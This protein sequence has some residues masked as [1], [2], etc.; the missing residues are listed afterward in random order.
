MNQS[1]AKYT[2]EEL[3]ELS[4]KR[5]GELMR[6][7]STPKIE[8]VVGY[9]F[10]GYN[11]PWATKLMGTKKY[12]KG[13]YAQPGVSAY[14]WGYN[15]PVV[16]NRKTEPW[17]AV[18]NEANP[19]RYF[20]FKVFP[21]GTPGYDKKMAHALIIDY[22][23]WRYFFLNPIQRTLDYLV[24]PYPENRNLMVGRS[25]FFAGRIHF[26]MGYLILERHN[27]SNYEPLRKS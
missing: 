3:T 13:F 25:D 23:K 24:F 6:T 2:F 19:R 20:F 7:G 10:R 8:E 22:S 21:A 16:Q 11:V 12:K 15:V 1:N 14:A 18:P 4:N 5:L 27:K 26:P 17:L 9:E